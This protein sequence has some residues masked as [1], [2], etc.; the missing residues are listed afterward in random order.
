MATVAWVVVVQNDLDTY[1][2]NPQ[3]VAM[4]SAAKR[5]GQDAFTEV[6]PDIAA[7]VRQKVASCD[8]NQLST[9]ANSVP[10]ELLW[11]TCILII[12]SMFARLGMDMTDGQKEMVTKAESD[13][14]AVSRC[15]L[16][17]SNPTNPEESTY[18]TGQGVQLVSYRTRVADS[19]GTRGL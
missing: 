3:R 11:A 7:R 15:D 12:E 8:Q 5:A 2:N 16:T 18:Q 19:R 10:P 1:L 6:M 17:V 4:E 13:L 14:R 9:T